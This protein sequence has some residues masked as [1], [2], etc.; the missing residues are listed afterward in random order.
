M[1][2]YYRENL[3][4]IIMAI[5]ETDLLPPFIIPFL[6]EDAQLALENYF[7][8]L[9]K[10]TADVSQHNQMMSEWMTDWLNAHPGAQLP[11][12]DTCFSV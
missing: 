5:Q 3:G 12:W 10:H 2:Y 11:D 8:N 4:E 7:A 1:K 6:D 9:R